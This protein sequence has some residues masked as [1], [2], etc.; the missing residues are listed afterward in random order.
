METFV[1]SAGGKVLHGAGRRKAPRSC[2]LHMRAAA[3]GAEGFVRRPVRSTM[4]WSYNVGLPAAEEFELF[5]AQ[6]TKRG[7]STKVVRKCVRIQP[8]VF[9]EPLP[10]DCSDGHGAAI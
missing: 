8:S 10:V 7:M 2:A 1:G 5:V 4:V 6:L 9:D 3:A